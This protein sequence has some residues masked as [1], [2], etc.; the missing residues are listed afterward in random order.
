M[1]EPR[2]TD[3]RQAINTLL[4][5]CSVEITP[6][7]TKSINVAATTLPENTETFVASLP[8]GHLDDVVDT[9]IRV[10]REVLH[11]VPHLAARNLS[12]AAHLERLLQRLS[13]EAGVDE[14]ALV[15]GGNRPEPI[16]PY[17]QSLQILNSG[18]LE[19]YRVRSVYL[20]C[21]RRTPTHR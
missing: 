15:I 3:L 2:E 12:S 7:D 16:G 14:R 8:N 18:L 13:G 5:G 10:R 17:S 11:P 19:K 20:S 1:P 6:G 4:R 21:Y 9:A